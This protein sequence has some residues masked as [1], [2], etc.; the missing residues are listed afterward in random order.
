MANSPQVNGGRE[1]S[2]TEQKMPLLGSLLRRMLTAQNTVSNT[3]TTTSSSALTKLTGDVTTSTSGTAPATVTGVNQA[4]VPASA[5]ILGT[6]AQGQLI[7]TSAVLPVNAPA[8]AHKWIDAYDEATG[9]FTQTQP[10]FADISGTATPAQLPVATTSV[11][12]VV[13]PDGTTIT[14]AA[15]VI[16]AVGGGG[17]PAPTTVIAT[18]AVSEL[19]LTGAI[20]SSYRDYDIRFS[21]IVVASGSGVVLRIQFSINNGSTWDT[22][23]VYQ[24]GRYYAQ[25]GSAAGGFAGGGTDIGIIPTLAAADT[26]SEG[27]IVESRMRFNFP[28]NTGDSV[29]MG[30]IDTEVYQGSSSS[31]Y[32]TAGGFFYPNSSGVNALR[33][34]CS[35]GGTFTGQ[36]TCQ[37][38]PQ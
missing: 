15:G 10:G 22:S 1:L 4:P 26:F 2:W 6:N 27:Y 21:H 5:G 12:G 36:I 23:D 31:T 8:V 35:G 25:I 29:K 34:V 17:Y 32:Q 13:E 7:E 9:D 19:D 16:S 11:L 3:A 28:L 30:A 33:L 20:T 14:I 37:P 38:L 24:Y 18:T